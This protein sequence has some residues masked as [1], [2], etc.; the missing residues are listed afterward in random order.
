MQ[1]YLFQNALHSETY[2]LYQVAFSSSQNEET[3]CARF[4]DIFFFAFHACSDSCQLS[5]DIMS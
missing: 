2:G 3:K 5:D 4:S 1:S